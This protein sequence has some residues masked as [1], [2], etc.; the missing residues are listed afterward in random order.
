MLDMYGD[1][2]TKVVTQLK[3]QDDWDRLIQ[4]SDQQGTRVLPD[5]NDL[6]NAQEFRM[7]PYA[8]ATGYSNQGWDVTAT[9]LNET[10]LTGRA[11]IDWQF[12]RYNR[13]RFG[14]DLQSGDVNYF[15]SPVLRQSFM[16]AYSED[17][18]RYGFYGED[19]LDLG[20]VVI[21]AGVRG[22][23]FDTGVLLSTIPGHIS[24]TAFDTDNPEP[25]LVQSSALAWPAERCPSVTDQTGF[26]LSYAHQVQS[27]TCRRS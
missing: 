9:L 20:D 22:D 17:P 18:V 12:D 24:R 1:D 4:T 16:D 7:N 14:G 23:F 21:E 13:F 5:R 8:L 25:S 3:S 2:A 26:R 11:N 6:R 10:R 27:P 15:S 19:R